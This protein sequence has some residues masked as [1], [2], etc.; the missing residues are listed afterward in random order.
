MPTRSVR[1]KEWYA[2]QPRALRALSVVGAGAVLA[3]VGLVAPAIG[4]IVVGATGVA[5]A[6]FLSR[7]LTAQGKRSADVDR[8][9]R[10]TAIDDGDIEVTS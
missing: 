4:A 6:T 5:S 7:A 10:A 8:R 3:G 9:A 1:V 2:R